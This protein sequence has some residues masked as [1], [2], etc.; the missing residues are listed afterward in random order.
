MEQHQL[1]D[2]DHSS[3]KTPNTDT[4]Q[5]NNDGADTS[6]EIEEGVDATQMSLDDES[7]TINEGQPMQTSPLESIK[8]L[9]PKLVY[10]PPPP[11]LD[12]CSPILVAI[13]A[14]VNLLLSSWISGF[15]SGLVI[16]GVATYWICCYLTPSVSYSSLVEPTASTD[17]I[18]I[19]EPPSV[20]QAWMN[21]LPPQF[22]PYDV[23]TYEV[24]NTVSV[25]ISVEHHMMK[26]EYPETNIPKRLNTDE[27]IPNDISFLYHSDHIDLTKAKISL[28]P[29][30]I[31]GKR[32]FSKKYPIE[33]R[34]NGLANNESQQPTSLIKNRKYSRSKESIN[35][36]DSE[37]FKDVLGT[38]TKQAPTIE[39][40]DNKSFYLFARADREKEDIYKFLIDSHH[41]LTDTVLDVARRDGAIVDGIDRDA[42]GRE[43]VRERKSKFNDFMDR[44][45]ENSKK[46][47]KEDPTVMFLNVYLNRIF[48]DIHKSKKSFSSLSSF[49]ELLMLCSKSFHRRQK[50]SEPMLGWKKLSAKS[51]YIRTI[52]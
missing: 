9:K 42:G 19:H 6:G 39:A 5:H 38:P 7:N 17:K 25:R 47:S 35:S 41:F 11:F 26:I 1:P 43:T 30:G 44:V 14:V 15:L 33:I 4:P 40:Q 32:M 50:L 10:N 45:I 36:D 31:A 22:Q 34:T 51:P 29:D 2:E 20:F 37:N 27:I 52:F 24:K 23:D 46:E 18:E 16:A 8:P 13:L 28:L 49:K 48:Y 21:L 3:F 12:L